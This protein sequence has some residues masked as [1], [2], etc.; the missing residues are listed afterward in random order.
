MIITTCLFAWIPG[1]GRARP[2][3]PSRYSRRSRSPGG[4]A[5]R[6]RRAAR[7]C[8]RQPTPGGAAHARQCRERDDAARRLPRGA[9]G[10][11]RLFT[12]VYDAA[13]ATRSS[14]SGARRGGTRSRRG[15]MRGRGAAV[16][17]ARDGHRAR[18]RRPDG[19]G[20]DDRDARPRGT[21]RPEHA[22]HRDDDDGDDA[23]SPKGD[24]VA[25]KQIFLGLVGMHRLPHAR[26]RGLERKRRAE[27]RRREAELDTVVTQVTNGQRRHAAVRDTLTAQQI[28]DVAAYVSSVAGK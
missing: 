18:F 28:A 20:D 26:G 25:G 15:G 21:R 3:W 27:P 9:T 11:T 19:D 22:D 1:A 8:E 14:H 6:R 10:R 7:R 13:D 5:T 4:R 16:G 17:D 23:G 12:P 2:R 24:P